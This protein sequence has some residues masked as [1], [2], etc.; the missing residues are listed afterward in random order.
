MLALLSTCLLAV[1]PS[2]AASR[3]GPDAI[4]Q[5]ATYRSPDGHW[6]LDVDPSRRDGGGAGVY[7]VKN[8]GQLAWS[9]GRPWTFWDATVT[10][11]G[12][13]GGYAYTGG[14]GRSD[15]DFHIVVVS[16]RGEVRAE[17]RVPRKS[18]R[19]IDGGP[20]PTGSSIVYLEAAERLIFRFFDDDE[21]N[22]GEQWIGY[23]LPDAK[24][25]FRKRPQAQL[26]PSKASLYRPVI[27]PVRG[28]P[29]FV[30]QWER[31]DFGGASSHQGAHFGLFDADADLV[32]QLVRPDDWDLGD[33]TATDRLQDRMREGAGLL[34]VSAPRQFALWAPASHER[35][36]FEVKPAPGE[37]PPW[38]V[39]DLGSKPQPDL[40]GEH[41][42]PVGAVPELHLEERAVVDLE[43]GTSGPASPIRDIAA[44]AF[45]SAQALRVVRKETAPNEF[46]LLHVDAAGQVLGEHKVTIDGSQADIQIQWWPVSDHVWVVTQ[47]PYGAGAKSIA[48]SVDDRSASVSALSAFDFPSIKDLAGFGDGR[49]V[50]L[51]T[52][53]TEYTMT[54]LVGAF[55]AAGTLA[56]KV[57]GGFGGNTPESL[58]SPESLAVTG[59]GRVLL[60]D[61]IRKTLQLFDQSGHFVRSV[62][63]EK[64]LGQAPNYPSRVTWDVDNGVLLQDFDGKPPLWRLDAADAVR[65]KLTPTLRDGRAM[66]DLQLHARVAPDGRIWS[67]DGARLLRLDEKGVVDL[68]LGDTVS[69]EK[70]GDPAVAAIDALGRVLIQDRKTGAV[71]VFS[72]EGKRIFVGKPAPQD[73]G[74]TNLLD[75]IGATRGGGVMVHHGKGEFILFG[76]Q[77]EPLGVRGGVP[78]DFS[79]SPVTG[80]GAGTRYGDGWLLYD[81]NW[82]ELK[83][84]ERRPDRFWIQHLSQPAF[85]PDGT[86]A[87]VEHGT[88]PTAK[89]GFGALLVYSQSS[90]DGRILPLSEGIAA[91][92]VVLSRTRAVLFSWDPE[93][94]VLDLQT[95]KTSHFAAGATKA[96]SEWRW[97]FS[98]DGNELLGLEPRQKRLHRFALP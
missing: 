32:W 3:R 13:V 81:E 59:D 22:P 23:Q 46:T 17:E 76:P 47:S 18:S 35:L 11:G 96:K 42:A 10:N 71:H 67:T 83:H 29:L 72:P 90:G 52:E 51:G 26:E 88:L 15:G 14:V 70:L 6:T 86:I 97:G 19:V 63:L 48:W 31:Y 74:S 21:K 28:T 55:D 69:P 64:A 82:K 56:W 40:V 12:F 77:G 73:V 68:E 84:F 36:E 5:P 94:W 66:Y 20:L 61:N 8:D 44:F 25:V 92:S 62:D 85:G 7:A 53:R 41:G 87:M 91:H 78:H 57:G 60:V 93:C 27:Q 75:A 30:A 43:S 45:E 89:D 65:G 2:N 37:T 58:L 24:E 33:E 50:V 34:E 98:A 79:A 38:K 54:D 9:G 4:L 16:P 49:F 80:M 95:G 39:T 1:V